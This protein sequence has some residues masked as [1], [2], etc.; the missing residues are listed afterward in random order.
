MRDSDV[1]GSV[2]SVG[3][4]VEPDDV[5]EEICNFTDEQRAEAEEAPDKAVMDLPP[6]LNALSTACIIA[7][8]MVGKIKHI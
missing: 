4:R 3:S 5:E 6:M 2:R 8:R 7:N 1:E